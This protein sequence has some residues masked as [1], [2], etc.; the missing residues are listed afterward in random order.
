MREKYDVV[1]IGSGFGG[2]VTACRLAQAGRSVCVLEQGRWWKKEEFPRSAGHFSRNAIWDPDRGTGFIEIK[3]FRKI[4]VIQ[5]V[6]VGGGSLHYFNTHLRAP[7]QI[8]EHPAWPEGTTRRTLDPYYELARDMLDA[9]PLTPPAGRT[10]S[11]KTEIFL[12][13]A[14]KAGGQ[15]VR[16][17][18]ICVHTGDDR[19][20]PHGGQARQRACEYCGNCLLGCHVQ[21]KNTLDL[22]YIALALQHGAEVYALH[23]ADRIEPRGDG[24]AVHFVRK[25]ED[26]TR[27]EEGQVLAGKVV[28]AAGTL[29]STEI[30]LRARDLHRTLPGLSPALGQRFSGNG[31]Y[32]FAGTTD[33][34]RDVDLGYGLPITAGAFFA[35]K[36]HLIQIQDLGTPEGFAWYL[37]GVLPSWR[38]AKNILQYLASYLLTAFGFDRDERLSPNLATLME[39]RVTKNLMLYL[40]M[41][42]D[43]ADGQI[44][45]SGRGRIEIAWDNAGSE[46]MFEEMRDIMRRLSAAAGGRFVDSFLWKWPIRKLL[47]AH[48]M[49]GCVMSDDP[50]KGVVNEYGEVWGYPNLYVAD[51]AI[52][53]TALVVNPSAT[54]TALAERVAF[55]MIHTRELKEGDPLTPRN[56]PI[57]A[58]AV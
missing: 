10:F 5:G 31:D 1:V 49:G 13:A 2:A 26:G 6:G 14:R 19:V 40:G 51:A 22:T 17:V 36:E 53:P 15:D 12:E 4:D 48:P 38:R 45:L 39:D 42:T 35:T 27:S 41:G 37:E 46:E 56:F 34:P 9:R 16:L 47:T 3:A 30:L 58:A 43:A 18:D 21:A 24:Y 50:Q 33:V 23:K 44:K 20:N 54:I 55:H 28:L 11:A 32:L 7:A 57:E 25:S 52:I 29:G 8:F